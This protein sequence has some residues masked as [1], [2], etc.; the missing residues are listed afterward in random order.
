MLPDTLHEFGDIVNETLEPIVKKARLEIDRAVKST[1]V[2]IKMWA[3][4]HLAIAKKLG[5]RTDL[6]E[7]LINDPIGST[8]KIAHRMLSVQTA[9]PSALTK[10]GPKSV[11]DVLY[12]IGTL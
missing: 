7:K 1:S 12:G 8:S 3:L 4:E 9:H 10:S 2:K 6:F 11:D 5:R